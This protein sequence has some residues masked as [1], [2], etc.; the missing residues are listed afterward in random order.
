LNPSPEED[1]AAILGSAPLAVA[2]EAHYVNGGL[3]SMVAEVI[4]ERGLDCR[5]IRAGVREMPAG[6]TGTSAYMFDQLGLSPNRL[7][8]VAAQALVA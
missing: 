8:D 4:A 5:L 6:L 1:L 2:A 7:A 3:G